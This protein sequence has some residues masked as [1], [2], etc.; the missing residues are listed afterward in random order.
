MIYNCPITTRV[1][2]LAYEDMSLDIS[3]S[4]TLSEYK[5]EMAQ[6]ALART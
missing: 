1:N 3:S 6:Q 2:R 4:K 5:H